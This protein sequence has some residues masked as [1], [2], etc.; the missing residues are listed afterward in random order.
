MSRSTQP[1]YNVVQ[2]ELESGIKRI[3]DT[4]ER[5]EE[6]FTTIS[7]QLPVLNERLDHVL[8]ASEVLANKVDK[9]SSLVIEDGYKPSLVTR[10]DNL[11]KKE[12][13]GT[14]QRDKNFATFKW[15]TGIFLTVLTMVIGYVTSM[16]AT[17]SHNPVESPPI[18]STRSK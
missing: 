5:H 9:L 15:F 12:E 18:T 14:K 13:A 7:T 10:V 8:K 6:V 17:P 11:E 4:M 2:E 3:L 1:P 16:G